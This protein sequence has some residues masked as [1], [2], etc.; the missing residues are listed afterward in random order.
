MTSSTNRNPCTRSWLFVIFAAGALALAFGSFWPTYFGPVLTGIGEIDPIKHVWFIPVHALYFLG[1]IAAFGAQAYLV[2]SGRTKVHRRFGWWIV[3]YGALG[4]VL[5]LF[6]VF[7]MALRRVSHGGDVAEEAVF[8][9]PGLLDMVMFAG[10]LAAAVLL[11]TDRE[12]HKRLMVV[13]TCVMTLI[14]LGRLYPLLF[15]AAWLNPGATATLLY[16]APLWIVI[17]VDVAITRRLHPVYWI[18][19]PLFVLKVNQGVIMDSPQWQ[20]IGLTLLNWFL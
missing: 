8:L 5:G 20:S 16:A 12:S 13:A 2:R 14:G 1:W 19:I 4:V 18:A 15:P 9:F 17:L 6:A 7:A 3:G 10:F 11:R